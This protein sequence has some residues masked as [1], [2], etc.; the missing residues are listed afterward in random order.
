MAG[1][2]PVEMMLRGMARWA[3][4]VGCFVAPVLFAS[5]FAL[6]Q[7][8]EPTG[9]PPPDPKALVETPT[10]SEAAPSFDDAMQG[11]TTSLSAGG[12]RL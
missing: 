11:T 7:Q 6:A 2:R 12:P 4:R 5:S 9:A 8:T 1:P 3:R 10:A